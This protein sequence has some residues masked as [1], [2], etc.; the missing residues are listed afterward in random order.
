MPRCSWPAFEGQRFSFSA[1][2]LVLGSLESM[3]RGNFFESTL[4]RFVRSLVERQKAPRRRLP[5]THMLL[6]NESVQRARAIIISSA[7]SNGYQFSLKLVPR[8][9]PLSYNKHNFILM[10]IWITR[11]DVGEIKSVARSIGAIKTHFLEYNVHKLLTANEKL[12][13]QLRLHAT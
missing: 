13:R 1:L 9:E 4:H 2:L 7:W 11:A 12:H 10:S 5:V 3:W 6:F 8:K